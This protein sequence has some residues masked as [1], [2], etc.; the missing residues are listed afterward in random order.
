MEKSALNQPFP[1]YFTVMGAYEKGAFI[2]KPRRG[3]I[4]KPGAKPLEM[5]E[6]CVEAL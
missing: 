1:L 5:G 2:R 3:V 6:G 4:C